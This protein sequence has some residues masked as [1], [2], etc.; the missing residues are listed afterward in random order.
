MFNKEKFAEILS[1]INKTYD[2][3]TEF[4][5][6]SGVNRTYLSQYINQKL[7]A[8][9]SPKVLMKIANNSHDITNYEYLMQVCGF[10]INEKTGKL[11]DVRKAQQTLKYDN[12]IKKINLSNS[13]QEVLNQLISYFN[14]N[15]NNN[16]TIEENEEKTLSIINKYKNIEHCDISKVKERF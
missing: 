5:E 16:L 15:Y 1:K 14:N 2:T 7:D 8:P 10:L 12:M 4:A 6:K 9:P 13:E 11:E 3:M